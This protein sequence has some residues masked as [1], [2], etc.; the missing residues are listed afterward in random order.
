MSKQ[1]TIIILCILLGVGVFSFAK[2]IDLFWDKNELSQRIEETLKPKIVQLELDNAKVNN[3]LKKVK[4]SLA[5]TEKS[6]LAIEQENTIIKDELIFERRDLKKTR[7]LLEER[8]EELVKIT[9]RHA[10]INSENKL[11]KEKFN[12]M[13]IEFLEMKRTLSSVE[14][15]REMIRELRTGSKKN[16]RITRIARRKYGKSRAGRKKGKSSDIEVFGN[17]GYLIRD[18]QSTYT[19]KVRIKVLTVDEE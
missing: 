19:P 15:L 18:G 6:L 5:K 3:E 12:A 10:E 8:K 4:K 14:A 16:S 7:T 1:A 11:L 9:N 2:S 13:Y 17:S